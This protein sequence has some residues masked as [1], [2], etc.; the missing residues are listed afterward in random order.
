MPPDL[1]GRIRDVIERVRRTDAD[2]AR[3]RV[4][5]ELAD[6]LAFRTEMHKEFA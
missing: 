4:L 5:H 1:A 2:P 6:T 3:L